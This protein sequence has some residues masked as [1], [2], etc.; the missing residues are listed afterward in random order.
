MSTFIGTCFGRLSTLGVSC[1]LM[2]LVTFYSLIL[3]S[4]LTFLAGINSTS[5]QVFVS[6]RTAGFL[7]HT[8][9]L[10]FH[11]LSTFNFLIFPSMAVPV[12]V[13][14]NVQQCVEGPC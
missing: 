8:N 3:V 10:V 2:G 12:P 9:I 11:S 4:R 13:V 14:F 1:F 5:C 6:P 7:K